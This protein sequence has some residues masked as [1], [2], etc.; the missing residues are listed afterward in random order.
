MF[1]NST[2][3]DSS[4]SSSEEYTLSGDAESSGAPNVSET[5]NSAEESEHEKNCLEEE[6]NNSE[7]YEDIFEMSGE[8]C[9]LL[10]QIYPSTV[11]PV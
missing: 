11:L 3:I 2:D 7:E 5:S 9:V 1:T 4:E 10:P 8:K 6:V